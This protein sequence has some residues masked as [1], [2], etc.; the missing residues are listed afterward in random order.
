MLSLSDTYAEAVTYAASAH[1]GQVRKGT[2]IPYISHP[3]AVS[4]LVIEH[5]GSE[6]QA[7]AGLLHDV[8]EDCGPHHGPVIARRFGQDVLRIVQGLTD[9]LPD[10][11]GHKPPWRQ[12]KEDY[13]AHLEAAN[14][15]VVLVSACDKLHNATA[16]ADDHASL[17]EA[18]FQRFSQPKVSTVW[19]YRELARV[20]AD[21]L[22]VDHPL[23]TKLNGALR[24]W[25]Y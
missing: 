9:G 15:Q 5:G 22:G 25:A 3:I 23:V 24:R 16:I 10:A 14:P 12:R 11:T 18:V 1:E 20:F 13:L 6:T 19:Y 8:L 7:I 21:R 2:C 4:A 17:G